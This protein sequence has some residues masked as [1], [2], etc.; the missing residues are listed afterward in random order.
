MLQI[1]YDF[2]RL[3]VP[4]SVHRGRILLSGDGNSTH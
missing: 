1:S 3:I 2:E 4:V